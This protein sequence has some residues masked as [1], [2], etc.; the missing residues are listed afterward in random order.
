[1]THRYHLNLTAPGA[2]PEEFTLHDATK[3]V[4]PEH[5]PLCTQTPH[6]KTATDEVQAPVTAAK[7]LQDLAPPASGVIFTS[8]FT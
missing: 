3:V 6:E 2:T 5:K 7:V 4:D 8:H 1:M